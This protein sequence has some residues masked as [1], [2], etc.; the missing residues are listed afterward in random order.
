VVAPVG[1]ATLMAALDPLARKTS[2][3]DERSYPQRMA[4][5]LVELA[6]RSLDAGDLLDGV[7]AVSSATVQLLGCDAETTQVFMSRNGAVLDAGRTRRE[8]TRLSGSR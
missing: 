3:A 4:D 2:H 8:P 6:R 5:A 1:G 7:G